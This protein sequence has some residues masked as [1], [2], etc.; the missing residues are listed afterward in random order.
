MEALS[1]KTAIGKGI[2]TDALKGYYSVEFSLDKPRPLYHF[3]I[4]K[5]ESNPMFM[6]VQKNSNILS[7]LKTGSVLNMTYYSTNTRKSME[8]RIGP[9]I[10][11]EKGRFHGHY[12]VDLVPVLSTSVSN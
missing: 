11:K 3:K 7:K 10:D 6:V 8:T 4:W 12:T 1:Q 9:I 5:S 2:K